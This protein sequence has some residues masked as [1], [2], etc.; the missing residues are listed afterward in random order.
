MVLEKIK[1]I[2]KDFPKENWVNAKCPYCFGEIIKCGNWPYY[3]NEC[4][5]CGMKINL[6]SY[7]DAIEKI[8]ELNNRRSKNLFWANNTD[9]DSGL[10]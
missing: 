7:I 3:W 9:I 8:L 4:K 10:Y 1:K 6:F 2:I 5:E